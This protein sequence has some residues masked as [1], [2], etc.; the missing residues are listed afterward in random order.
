M[1]SGRLKDRVA[2]VTGGA[3]GI[4]RRIAELFASE[5][6]HL[7]IGDLDA[8]AGRRTVESIRGDGHDALFVECDISQEEGVRRLAEAA[9]NGF[10]RIDILVNNAGI[11]RSDTVAETSAEDW[12]RVMEVNL[13]GTFLCSRAVLRPMMRQ[14]SG[15]IINISSRAGKKG[16]A[17]AGA[18]AASKGGVIAFTYS[19]MLEV[20]EL[21]IR[22]NA[23]CPGM[24]HTTMGDGSPVMPGER[25]IEPEEIAR[26]ALFLASDEGSAVNGAAV[27]AYG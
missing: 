27:N 13:K 21:G 25:W 12:D 4:G 20:K 22:V 17:E 26:V 23:I 19:L 15:V 14:K 8:E 6:A 11:Y 24:V 18:Y 2:I 9:V 5:G 7:V 3:D 16:L 1:G 10:E